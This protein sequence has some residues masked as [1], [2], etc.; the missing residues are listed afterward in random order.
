MRDPRK[1]V[2]EGKGE[3]LEWEG[4]SE[5]GRV[6]QSLGRRENKENGTSSA[7]HFLSSASTSSRGTV[8]GIRT[9]IAA[10]ASGGMQ[11]TANPSEKAGP[12]TKP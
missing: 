7:V 12:G 5:R 11:F 4:I 6:A 3:G 9:S 2:K 8:G 10:M 1:G